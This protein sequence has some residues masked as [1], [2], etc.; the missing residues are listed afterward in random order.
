MNLD[1]CNVKGYTAWSLMDNLEWRAGYSEK[2]GLHF[3]NFTDPNRTR[4]AKASSLFFHN[5]IKNH[6]FPKGKVLA[7]A[8]PG[9]IAYENEFLYDTFPENFVWSTATAAYQVEGGWDQDGKICLY[10]CRM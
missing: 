6:G 10:I 9:S 5:L 3:V 8:A 2:F 1:K 4:T 7:P